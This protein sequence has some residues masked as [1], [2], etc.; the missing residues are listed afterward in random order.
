MSLE[1]VVGL[2]VGLGLEVDGF[3]DGMMMMLK[4][5]FVMNKVRF[6]V[7]MSE[8][9]SWWT[10]SVESFVRN[11]NIFRRNKGKSY[12]NLFLKI[13]REKTSFGNPLFNSQ[14]V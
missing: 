12:L 7:I 5:S 11:T 9:F 1:L 3:E 4:I 8:S 13:V 2:G 6:H 10:M 14:R